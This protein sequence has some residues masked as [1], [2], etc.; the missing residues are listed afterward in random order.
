MSLWAARYPRPRHPARI[1]KDND[2]L[3]VRNNLGSTFGETQRKTKQQ[4]Q[5][6]PCQAMN[7][8]VSLHFLGY[9][10]SSRLL[11][12]PLRRGPRYPASATRPART[13]RRRSRKRASRS[14][15]VKEKIES[16]KRYRGS[17]RSN[18]HTNIKFSARL[19]LEISSVFRS[20]S[21]NS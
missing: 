17:G 2:C 10:L 18:H 5:E 7:C 8:S 13:R 19:P 15:A 9:I 12:L 6:E 21:L 11:S 16:I 4:Q 3:A 14:R 1:E 20:H